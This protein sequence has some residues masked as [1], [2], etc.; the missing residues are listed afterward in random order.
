MTIRSRS[1]RRASF[2]G[3]SSSKAKNQKRSRRKQLALTHSTSTSSRS[4]TTLTG[5]LL[6]STVPLL[7]KPPYCFA[8]RFGTLHASDSSEFDTAGGLCSVRSLYRCA[9]WHLHLPRVP[10]GSHLALFASLFHP[11]LPIHPLL[12]VCSMPP[13]FLPRRCLYLVFSFSMSFIY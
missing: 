2:R 11:F 8:I 10:T 7:L 13:A 6:A 9:L 12:V 4:K 3:H 5:I 1:A